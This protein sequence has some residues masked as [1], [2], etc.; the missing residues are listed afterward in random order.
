VKTITVGADVSEFRYKLWS[1]ITVAT[2]AKDVLFSSYRLIILEKLVER[3]SCQL[4][5]TPQRQSC[6]DS[7]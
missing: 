7:S 3:W 6:Y 1:R 5:A 4:P 2:L